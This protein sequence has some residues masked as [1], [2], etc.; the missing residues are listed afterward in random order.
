MAIRQKE[1]YFS[2]VARLYYRNYCFLQRLYIEDGFSIDLWRQK[3][4]L[5][6]ILTYF[7]WFLICLY[8]CSLILVLSKV[9]LKND[10]VS[11][12]AI[13][14]ISLVFPTNV[15]YINAF[16]PF[17]WFGSLFKKYVWNKHDRYLFWPS[18]AIYLLVYIIFW[19]SSFL[20]Y[21]HDGIVINFTKEGTFNKASLYGNTIRLITGIT[22]SLLVITLVK[23][24]TQY[25]IA[26]R[27]F[28]IGHNTLGIYVLQFVLFNISFLAI[29]INNSHWIT[30]V[31][32][33]IMLTIILNQLVIMIRKNRFGKLLLLGER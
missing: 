2:D 21:S 26:D 32:F 13:I 31:L 12:I 17:V 25:K 29:Y 9:I 30:S 1:N 24:L 6:Y 10:F 8:V 22:G 11:T 16:L 20:C 33:G 18:A 14:L 19:D 4:S 5:G 15:L 7:P 27:I 28:N 23:Y 3:H